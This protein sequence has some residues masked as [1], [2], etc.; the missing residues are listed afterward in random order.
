MFV[1]SYKCWEIIKFSTFSTISNLRSNLIK[2]RIRNS[3]ETCK[4]FN[5]FVFCSKLIPTN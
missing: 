3:K 1:K 5:H 2:G 4:I